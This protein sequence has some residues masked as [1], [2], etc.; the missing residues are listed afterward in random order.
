MIGGGSV[1]PPR[2]RHG[3]QCPRRHPPP[4]PPFPACHYPYQ[5]HRCVASIYVEIS[6]ATCLL[7]HGHG[8]QGADSVAA[9]SSSPPPVPSS[10]RKQWLALPHM[11]NSF[12][13]CFIADGKFYCFIVSSFAQTNPFNSDHEPGYRSPDF[14]RPSDDNIIG[15][16]CHFQSAGL[17]L[18]T[19][20]SNILCY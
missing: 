20:V 2:A 17:Q 16:V 9:T 15:F 1:P 18:V 12:F 13:F 6:V 19:V 4:P 10:P 8:R 7:M 14:Q 3:A 5:A 11:R